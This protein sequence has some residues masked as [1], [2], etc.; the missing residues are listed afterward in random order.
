MFIS[1]VRFTTLVIVMLSLAMVSSAQEDTNTPTIDAESVI[2][3]LN[4]AHEQYTTLHTHIVNEHHS[5]ATLT[6]EVWVSPSEGL[7]R[8]ETNTYSPIGE[9]YQQSLLV[10]NGS[11]S[12]H[13]SSRRAPVIA[14]VGFEPEEAV[15]SLGGISTM[16]APVDLAKRLGETDITLEDTGFETIG[17]REASKLLLREPKATE[18]QSLGM[19][20]WVDVETGII[21][22][23]E[24][25]A[26]DGSIFST[27]TIESIEFDVSFEDQPDLFY[28]DQSASGPPV[29]PMTVFQTPTPGQ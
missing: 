2:N 27:T 25:L 17:D 26:N 5:G 8:V 14:P 4:T 22:R 9:I 15:F 16:I 19:N 29:P 24:Y 28:I 6:H 13:E 1:Y 10:I 12:Y 18:L 11:L 21:L 20:V 7:A 23:L 3:T